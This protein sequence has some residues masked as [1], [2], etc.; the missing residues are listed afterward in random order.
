MESLCILLVIFFMIIALFS[1]K[2]KGNM[3]YR[4]NPKPTIPK[5]NV[6]PPSQKFQ[7]K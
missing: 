7:G 2:T 1:G 5:P 3:G 6:T 4:I